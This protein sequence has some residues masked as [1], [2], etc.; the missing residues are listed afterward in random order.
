MKASLFEIG[1][2]K[3]SAVQKFG[4]ALHPRNIM[5]G[6]L[7]ACHQGYHGTASGNLP[8]HL[9][10]VALR[11]SSPLPGL[12]G[13]SSIYNMYDQLND[14]VGILLVHVCVYL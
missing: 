9:L 12:T 2:R 1:I 14:I 3:S 13:L 10:T 6:F 11:A 5:C 4:Q 7:T 8:C